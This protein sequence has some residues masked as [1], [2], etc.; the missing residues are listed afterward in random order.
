MQFRQEV[1]YMDTQFHQGNFGQAVEKFDSM[2]QQQWQQQPSL[3]ERMGKMDDTLQQLMQMSDSHHKST[4]VA[5]RRIGMQ[6][7]HILQKLDDFGAN[8]EVNPREECQAIITRSDKVLDERKIRRK[9]ER[10]SEKEKDV[11]EEEEKEERK[12]EVERKENGKNVE[13]ERKET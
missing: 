9:E 5:F 13:E 6:L 12:S 7:G 8:M 11:K 1:N 3:L 4:Q 2:P 10:L